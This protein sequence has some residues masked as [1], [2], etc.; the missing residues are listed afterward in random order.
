MT[1]A[2]TTAARKIIVTSRIA[3]NVYGEFEYHAPALGT[4]PNTAQT[5]A[6]LRE[7][8]SAQ[9]FE[10]RARQRLP[11][12]AINPQN[13]AHI[14][15]ICIRLE[16]IALAIELAAARVHETPLAAL[17]AALRRAP[18]AGNTWL[19]DLNSSARDLPLRQQRLGEAIRWSFDL[20]P[21]DQQRL[22]ARLGV[23]VG[24]FDTEAVL[25][26]C[27]ESADHATIGGALEA[28]AAHSLI[29]RDTTPG[30]WRLLEMMR[31]FAN[32]FA[33][34][35]LGLEGN[36]IARLRH[37]NYYA[38]WAG[39]IGDA[40]QTADD[41][42]VLAAYA[43]DMDNMSAGLGWAVGHGLGSLAC[44]LCMHLSYLWELRGDYV[45]GLGWIQ[46]TLALPRSSADDCV[47][48]AILSSG[49][50]L[51]WLQQQHDTA[52]RMV[53]ALLES[54]RRDGALKD[55][56]DGLQARAKVELEMGRGQDAIMTARELLELAST[57]NP[58]S[59]TA[60]NCLL[61]E[62]W[63]A[64]GDTA[65]AVQF[66]DEAVHRAGTRIDQGLWLSMTCAWMTEVWIQRHDFSAARDWLGR[67]L[68]H[69]LDRV[70]QTRLLATVAA[71]L[72][73]A[74]PGRGVN[75]LAMSARLWGAVD[76]L[77]RR[78][79]GA[80]LRLAR[81]Q[82]EPR[83]AAARR[84]MGN[85]AWEKAFREGAAWPPERIVAEVRVLLG[86]DE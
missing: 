58:G 5:P 79:G 23:F 46:V 78:I 30:R 40:L 47:R 66:L 17:A 55:V 85:L 7:V 49:V 21:A 14:A 24:S 32:G 54:A 37:A 4:P 13:A 75:P 43:S 26:V 53:E 73:A 76:A 6:E 20:L 81:Q 72:L 35:H 22:F 77:N 64:L 70:N 48:R 29:Q 10:A 80:P 2:C 51:A 41:R 57:V 18:E 86:E 3:L 62:A 45:E 83:V 84:R 28:L 31:E 42:T 25:G 12:F 59:L 15:D 1:S 34:A 33:R 39:R 60:A 56:C 65:R 68:R 63:L 82:A 69:L 74:E 67:W 71:G 38:I 8:E 27:A 44:N 61:G 16:G 11:A 52:L 36:E 19:N 9:L 50:N